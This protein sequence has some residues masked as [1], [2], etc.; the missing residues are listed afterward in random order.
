M[1]ASP[2][3]AQERLTKPSESDEVDAYMSEL[4]HPLAEVAKALRA[5]ILQT[6]PTIGEEIKWN[7]PAFF[8]SGELPPFDPKEYKRHIVVFNFYKRDCL[9]L[10]F[11]SGARLSDKSG[12]LEGQYP[13]GRRIAQFRD[14]SDVESQQPVL[15]RLLKRW[16]T[17]LEKR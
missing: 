2:M 11:P 4:K 14:M 10:V 17:T 1:K 16:L 15:Q 12:L 3:K 7:A 6:D 5:I 8:Y 13:D 9:R